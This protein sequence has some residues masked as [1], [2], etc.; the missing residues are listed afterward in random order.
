VTQATNITAPGELALAIQTV[1]FLSVDAVEKAQNGHPGAP[2]GLSGIA[3]ELFANR[4]RYLPSDPVWPGRDRFVLSCGHA[5]ALLY[6]ILHVSGYAVSIDDLKGFRQ[7]GSKTPGH[8]EHGHTPGVETTT[9]PLGQG[10][11]TAVGLALAGKMT[12]ERLG[13]QRS[14]GEYR[15]YC[16][17]SDGDLMEGVSYEASSVA[18]HL[19]LK[20]LIV[21]YDDNHVTIDGDVALSMSEDAT[22]RFAAQGW[23][24][25]RIDGHDAK[26]LQDALTA[27]EA[28]DKPSLIAARTR[29]GFGSPNKE[30]KSSSHGSPLGAEEVKRTKEALGWPLEPTFNVPSEALV[31]FQ[32][33]RARNE[34]EYKAWHGKLEALPAA[35][36]AHVE[37][38]FKVTLPANFAAEVYKAAGTAPGA[39]RVLSGKIE[40]KVAELVP[41]L[42]GGSADL[43]SSVRTSINGSSSVTRESF[44]GRN[45]N[46]GIREHGMGAILNGLALSGSFVPFGSTFLIF[47]DYMRPPMRLASLMKQRVIYVFTHDSIML[48]E[49]GP[50]HQPIEQLW[51]MRLVPGLDVFRPADALECAAAW[52]Y[53]LSRAD[54]PTVIVLSRQDLPYIEREAAFDPNQIV[55][56]AY[57]VRDL[58]K[59]EAVIIAT[60]SEVSTALAAATLLEARGRRLRVVSMPCVDAFLRLAADEQ[61]AI[62]PKGV[63]RVSVELGVTPPWKAL[64]GLDGLEIGIDTF[65]ASAPPEKLAEEFGMT[66]DHVANS[67]E[68]WLAAR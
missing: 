47:S 25:Q 35:E 5:S 63:P 36:R 20:N 49:D 32:K 53:A 16:L 55:R 3:V 51:S 68:S 17:A 26:A 24:T 60:G 27:A 56:G 23:F 38:Q 62:L 48:G 52:V 67:V 44:S 37:A 1:R 54:A 7:W 9:G 43:A 29:I 50:T 41:S 58:P 42:I 28:S 65:G 40:Q 13:E 6:S 59:P 10:I 12:A 57:V 21:I 11:A 39:T 19:G 46:F 22:A 45:I 64:T 30:G 33:Q 31:P 15:V 18:G 14:L 61:A 2:M 8:P 66:P 4:L 34:A